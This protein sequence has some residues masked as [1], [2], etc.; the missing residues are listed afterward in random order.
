MVA[1]DWAGWL[2]TYKP[3][4]DERPVRGNGTSVSVL[5]YHPPAIQGIS[6]EIEQGGVR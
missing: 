6:H 2:E 3:I 1:P 4:V 5:P